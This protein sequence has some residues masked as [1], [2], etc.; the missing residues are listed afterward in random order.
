MARF[1]DGWLQAAFSGALC[2]AILLLAGCGKP[3]GSKGATVEGKVTING[4][5]ATTGQV[6][7]TVGS[8][9]V[10]GQIQPDGTYRALDVPVGDAKVTVSAPTGPKMDSK[11]AAKMKEDTAMPGAGASAVPIPAKYGKAETSGLTFSVKAGDNK[12]DIELSK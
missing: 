7:F 2:L 1:R 9:S 10:S 5:S 3:S 8:S 12:Y 6:S 4:V 11:M